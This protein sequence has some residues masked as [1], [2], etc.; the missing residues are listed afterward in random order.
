VNVIKRLSPYLAAIMSGLFMMAAFA[1]FNL[2]LLAWIAPAGFIWAIYQ[3]PSKKMAGVAGFLY[4]MS[5]WTTSVSW[6]KNVVFEYGHLPETV[7]F[8]LMLLLCLFVSTIPVVLAIVLKGLIKHLGHGALFATP[9]LWVG[10][11]LFQTYLLTGFPWNFAGY[12]QVFFLPAVQIADHTGVYGVSFLIILVASAI[13]Y[14][15][16]EKPALNLGYV[17]PLASVGVVLILTLVYGFVV[18]SDNTE[19]RMF[20]VTMIQ[21]GLDNTGRYN[22]NNY[23]LFNFYL[24]ESVKAAKSGSDIVLWGE[25]A[26]LFL[27]MLGQDGGIPG[28]INEQYVLSLPRDFNFWL[29]MGSTDVV[30]G[31]NI[32]YNTALSAGPMNASAAQGFYR[33]V[34]LTPFGE[35]IPYQFVFGWLQKIVTEISDFKPGEEINTIPLLD[36]RA[37]T[38]ICYEVI[39]PDLVRRFSLNGATVLATL[40]NDAWFG[41]TAANDQHFNMAIMRAVEN[42]RYL[43]RCA[44]SGVSGVIDY[45]G[46]VTARTKPYEKTIL[47]GQAAMRDELTFYAT[48]GDV[49]AFFCSFVTVLLMALLVYRKKFDKKAAKEE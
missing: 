22:A 29:L 21:D 5:F 41:H 3:A 23:E 14:G 30:S 4:G 31:E 39:F 47:E 28:G 10:G 24:D 45:K 42:R 48:N 26:L 27:D 12:S 43:L 9:F 16:I 34:H 49:F 19:E 18:L 17:A 46:N 7:S 8:M 11:E 37:G 32:A 25:G 15:I 6:V 44:V 1:P 33:K 35:Y 38:P 40:S 20:E 2:W 36:G 13:V